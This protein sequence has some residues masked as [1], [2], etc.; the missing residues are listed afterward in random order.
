MN[1][2]KTT[3]RKI[4]RGFQVTIPRELREMLGLHVGDLVEFE[5]DM[6]GV[7]IR[8][9]EVKRKE[10]AEQLKRL[11]D[12]QP[13]NEFSNLSEDEIMAV[14]NEEIKKLREERRKKQDGK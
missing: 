13:E 7:V 3:V 2:T 5:Q 1:E 11:L 12:S 4:S 9:V 10:L 14:A 8:P 6:G